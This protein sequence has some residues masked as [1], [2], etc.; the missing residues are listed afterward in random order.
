[1]YIIPKVKRLRLAGMALGAF[2]GFAFGPVLAQAAW[3]DRL[4]SAFTGAP[5]ITTSALPAAAITTPYTFQWAAA[6]GRPPYRWSALAVPSTLTLSISGLLAGGM[7]QPAYI[8]VQV[9][10]SRQ[11]KGSK[12]LPLILCSVAAP[13]RILTMTLP[14]GIVGVP[15]SAQLEATGGAPVCTSP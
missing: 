13:L 1:M 14:D 4:V 3:W 15:Y 9:M 2:A 10:D 7:T 12:R 6:G 8:S 11:K 5:Y